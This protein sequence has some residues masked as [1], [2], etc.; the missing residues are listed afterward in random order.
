MEVTSSHETVCVC[1]GDH[2]IYVCTVDG[3]TT[4]ATMEWNCFQ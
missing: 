3:D 1:S 2:L 4:G